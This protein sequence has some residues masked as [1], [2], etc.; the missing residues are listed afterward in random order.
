MGEDRK[1]SKPKLIVK[2]TKADTYDQ[3]M[4]EWE[5]VVAFNKEQAEKLKGQ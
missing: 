1:A 2:I 5:E 3:R 4:K